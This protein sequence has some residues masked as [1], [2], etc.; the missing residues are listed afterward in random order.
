MPVVCGAGVAVAAAVAFFVK[1]VEP[2]KFPARHE[3]FHGKERDSQS[4]L[5]RRFKDVQTTAPD[6][7]IR[8]TTLHEE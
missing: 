4:D 7:S 6:D 5:L 3:A 2:S 8:F 1:F